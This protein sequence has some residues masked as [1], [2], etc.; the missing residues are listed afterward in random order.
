MSDESELKPPYVC[1]KHPKLYFK[2]PGSYKLH[3]ELQ[4]G[5]DA[6]LKGG[7]SKYSGKPYYS[8]GFGK[9]KDKT[10]HYEILI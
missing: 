7:I 3:I 2:D 4:H 5:K 10:R 8:N 1:F 9:Q 6:P